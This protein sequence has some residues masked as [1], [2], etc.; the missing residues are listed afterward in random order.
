MVRNLNVCNLIISVAYDGKNV[1]TTSRG[2]RAL[3]YRMNIADPSRQSPSY[4]FR[5][6]KYGKRGFSVAV[7]GLTNMKINSNIYGMTMKESSGL[8]RLLLLDFKYEIGVEISD[9]TDHLLKQWV[10]LVH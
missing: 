7:P 3:T 6:H 10:V 4:E 2:M 1:W 8:A 5:L 9:N